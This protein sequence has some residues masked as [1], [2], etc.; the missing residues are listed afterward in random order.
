MSNL[1]SPSF[2]LIAALGF[3]TAAVRALTGIAYLLMMISLIISG[4]ATMPPP[5]YVQMFSGISGMTAGPLFVVLM[6]CLMNFMPEDYKILG[7]I[8]LVFTA[9]F[10]GMVG[11]NRFVQFSIVR[12]AVLNGNTESV[13]RF[14]PYDTGSIMWAM[15]M[16]GWGLFL[17]LAALCM[18][19][20]FRKGGLEKAIRGLLITYGILGIITAIG[21]MT[22]PPLGALGFLAWGL[23]LPVALILVTIWFKRMKDAS[24]R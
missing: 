1:S 12:P 22:Y 13:L 17:G 4:N 14:M 9:L 18:I 8:G 24:S 19:P 10:A 6:A 20:L 21:C 5:D 7:Q 16:L 23:I 3:W 15:E 11:I 2:R